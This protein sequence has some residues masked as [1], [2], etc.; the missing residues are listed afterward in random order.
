MDVARPLRT[1]LS[2]ATPRRHRMSGLVS[3]LCGLLCA[4]LCA[5]VGSLSSTPAV[6]GYADAIYIG[7]GPAGGLGHRIAT[8]LCRLADGEGL[9]CIVWSLANQEEM[10]VPFLAKRAVN[11]ALI[12]S[13]AQHRGY[14]CTD[15][16]ALCY[17]GLRSVFAVAELPVQMLVPERSPA[18]EWGDLRG[19]RIGV[20]RTGATVLDD[21]DWLMSSGRG[22]FKRVEESSLEI[23]LAMLCDGDIDAALFV[24]IAPAPAIDRAADRCGVR[25]VERMRDE[26]RLRFFLDERKPYY[27]TMTIPSGTYRTTRRAV[28]TIGLSLTL[29]TTRN[30][31]NELVYEFTRVMAKGLRDRQPGRLA[32]RPLDRESMVRTGLSAPIHL[33]VLRFYKEAGWMRFFRDKAWV[34]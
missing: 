9:K 28:P 13:R 12:S 16:H 31:A 5:V 24:G 25:V 8:D 22:Y 7:S 20:G 27:S 6:G 26:K 14:Y 18:R 29:V 21:L 32:F 11:F 4:G 30:V 3:R 33:G 10:A 1:H 15:K 19:R 2:G 34:K 23:R 17:E